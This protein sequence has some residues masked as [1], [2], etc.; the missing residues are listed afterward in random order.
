MASGRN[1][2]MTAPTN[3]S[4]SKSSIDFAGGDTSG[5]TQINSQ[6]SSTIV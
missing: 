2:T 6:A 4:A 3:S 5:N 1:S